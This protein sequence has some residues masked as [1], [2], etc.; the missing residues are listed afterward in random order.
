M[1]DQPTC[2][3]ACTDET[4]RYAGV[5][6]TAIE[7]AKD[8]GARLILYAVDAGG[9][10]TDARPNKWAGEGEEQ[11]YDKPLGAI[12]LEKLGLHGLATQVQQAVSA[13]V[14]A[15]LWLPQ[16]NPAE[17]LAAYA[18][19]EGANLVLIPADIDPPEVAE[20]LRTE[21]ENATDLTVETV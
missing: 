9:T 4:G 1:A 17:E 8:S 2:I 7:R 21:T 16:G 18:T 14:D 10:F 11:V 5:L 19:R 6:S 13:G 3:V 12:E 15:S 20:Q